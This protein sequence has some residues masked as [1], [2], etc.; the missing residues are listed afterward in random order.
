MLHS[1]CKEQKRFGEAKGICATKQVTGMLPPFLH[2]QRAGQLPF[3]LLFVFG[4]Y[5]F[6]VTF[7]QTMQCGFVLVYTVLIGNVLAIG[8]VAYIYGKL[9]QRLCQHTCYEQQDQ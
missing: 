6:E 3:F 8:I 2:R 5:G 1:P 4:K 7:T 9:R